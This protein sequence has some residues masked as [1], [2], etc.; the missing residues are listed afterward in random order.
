M[1]AAIFQYSKNNACQINF[2]SCLFTWFNTEIEFILESKISIY[3]QI[4]YILYLGKTLG[5]ISFSGLDLIGYFAIILN[6]FLLFH[7]KTSEGINAI[8]ES[9]KM[10]VREKKKGFRPRLTQG[11]LFCCSQVIKR[12]ISFCTSEVF[13]INVLEL[14]YSGL[15]YPLGSIFNISESGYLFANIWD[16]VSISAAKG[17]INFLEKR[18]SGNVCWRG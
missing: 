4:R 2:L 1:I 12:N 15:K 3:L 11:I 16:H 5:I 18:H 14:K 7:L 8:S 17:I 13:W 6:I 9:T 10:A